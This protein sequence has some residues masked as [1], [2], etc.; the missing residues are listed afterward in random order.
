MEEID[1][2]ESKEELFLRKIKIL[3]PFVVSVKNVTGKLD[4]SIYNMCFSAS[5]R[6]GLE[7]ICNFYPDIAPSIIQDYEDTKEIL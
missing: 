5:E 3:R 6:V 4:E 2:F 1:I 7:W